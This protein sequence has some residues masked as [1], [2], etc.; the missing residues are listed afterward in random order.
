MLLR[1]ARASYIHK[2]QRETLA[3][4]GHTH[5]NLVPQHR[6]PCVFSL[7]SVSCCS[8]VSV[9]TDVTHDEMFS[10]RQTFS[11]SCVRRLHR[12]LSQHLVCFNT[13]SRYTPCGHISL[14]LL[15]FFFAVPVRA[16]PTSSAFST[17][18]NDDALSSSLL[19]D[20]VPHSG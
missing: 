11:S 19:H 13:T 14:L 18:P 2:H 9:L 7:S 20:K 12:E 10:L 6:L 17:T 1:D 4:E 5:Q 8:S 3:S 15:S 16:P